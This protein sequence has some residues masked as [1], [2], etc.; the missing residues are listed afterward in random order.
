MSH[1]FVDSNTPYV[2]SSYRNTRYVF[3]ERQQKRSK[4]VK[5]MLTNMRK[6]R[7]ERGMSLNDVASAIGVHPNAVSRWEKGQ[8]EPVASNLIALCKLYDASPEYLL[9]MTDE[10]HAVAVAN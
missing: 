4:E 3:F 1:I 2:Y 6:E 8:S 5:S 7:L 9:G 10:K